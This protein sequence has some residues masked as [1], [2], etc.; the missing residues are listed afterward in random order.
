MLGTANKG[1]T[2]PGLD[3][4]SN[5]EHKYTLVRVTQDGPRTKPTQSRV[6]LVSKLVRTKIPREDHKSPPGLC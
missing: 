2:S 5:E 4:S 1:G 6:A 3:D